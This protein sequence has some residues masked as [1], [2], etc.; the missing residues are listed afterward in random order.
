MPDPC[1]SVF[2]LLPDSSTEDQTLHGNM[3][4]DKRKPAWCNQHP[5]EAQE[6]KSLGTALNSLLLSLAK[7]YGTINTLQA[8]AHFFNKK[9][10]VFLQCKVF[11]TI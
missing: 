8:P 11:F 9:K 2:V 4:M 1:T 3:I 5:I 7:K 10:E 6:K